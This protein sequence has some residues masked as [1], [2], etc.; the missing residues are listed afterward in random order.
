MK[1]F[2]QKVVDLSH[3]DNMQAWVALC[4]NRTYL[5]P[6]HH[7]ICFDIALGIMHNIIHVVA[8][9][10]RA[11]EQIELTAQLNV[12]NMDQAGLGKVRFV[13]AWALSKILQKSKRYVKEHLY[14]RLTLTDILRGS[15]C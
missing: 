3:G 15:Q 1:D 5:K 9:A 12:K 11:K 7:S 14:T 13:G 4:F 6:E 8:V 2:Y 10:A